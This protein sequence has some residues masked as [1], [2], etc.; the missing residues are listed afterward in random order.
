[1][2]P[3]YFPSRL[4][5]RGRAAASLLFLLSLNPAVLVDPTKHLLMPNQRVLWV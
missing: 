3:S 4:Q 2:P 1:M 5:I